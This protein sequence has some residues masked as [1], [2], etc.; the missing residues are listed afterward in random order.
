MTDLPT[1][2]KQA[3]IE[4]ALVVF[5]NESVE[6][7]F[8]RLEA[9]DLGHLAVPALLIAALGVRVAPGG[10][11]KQTQLSSLAA[12]NCSQV[13]YAAVEWALDALEVRQ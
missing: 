3:L 1:E 11:W 4:K 10:R 9:C 8:D 2:D 5:T 7:F 12:S 6:L 13:V